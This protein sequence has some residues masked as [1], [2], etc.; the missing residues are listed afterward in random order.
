MLKKVLISLGILSLTGGAAYYFYKQYQLVKAWDFKIVGVSLLNYSSQTLTLEVSMKIT[1]PSS[2]EAT[3]SKLNG[4]VTINGQF[5]GNIFQTGVM[6]IPS[7]GYNIIKLD[8]Q[9]D[10]ENTI[11]QILSIAGQGSDGAMEIHTIGTLL[12]KS[13]F[14]GVTVPIDDTSNYTLG[15]LL[16]GG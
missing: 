7:E 14:I 2:V 5:I 11:N 13:G 12:V 1:N 3:V 16:S 15:Q 9:L 10:N 4:S 8:V 6:P